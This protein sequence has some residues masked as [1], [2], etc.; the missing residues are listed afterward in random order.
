MKSFMNYILSKFAII[1]LMPE[2]N[3]VSDLIRVKMSQKAYCEKEKFKI[4]V[5][6]NGLNDL[7][8]GQ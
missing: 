4:S 7:T 3:F 8:A 1:V 6:K 5:D 2:I